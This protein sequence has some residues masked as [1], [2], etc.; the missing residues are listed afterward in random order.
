M[1]NG[2]SQTWLDTALR[3]VWTR[4]F[5]DVPAANDVGILYCR[6]SKTRLG[7]IALSESGR[8]TRIG[9]NRLLRHREVPEEIAI[10]TIAH[11]LVHY[12]HGFGSPLP[13]RFADPHAGGIV[14]QELAIRGLGGALQRYQDW[15]MTTWTAFYAR[16][17]PSAARCAGM[18]GLT[19]ASREDPLPSIPTIAAS[20]AF[21]GAPPFSE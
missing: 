5:D 21:G 9:I 19:D 1:G 16:W 10:V 2:R 14:E 3:D 20:D 18:S 11:E 12:G 17:G 15:V 13:Q 6:P 4:H 7:W 8:S